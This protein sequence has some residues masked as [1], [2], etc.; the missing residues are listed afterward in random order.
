[1]GHRQEIYG[2]SGW[3]LIGPLVTRAPEWVADLG[4]KC[5]SPIEQIFVC[6][7]SLVVLTIH[8][9]WRPT[10]SVQVPIGPYRADIVIVDANGAPR[11]AIECDG[12]DFHKDKKRDAKRT[13]FIESMGYR[14][15]RLTGSEIHHNPLALAKNLLRDLGL[16]R[17]PARPY[18][19]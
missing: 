4:S 5:E 15:V 6:A 7:L 11:I 16:P 14:V 10:I 17:P 18:S 3:Q 13:A 1:M 12:A 9:A 2:I 8:E 19:H